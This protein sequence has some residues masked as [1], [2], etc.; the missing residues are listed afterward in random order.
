[1]FPFFELVL[2]VPSGA[3]SA[4]SALPQPKLSNVIRLK[5]AG[6]VTRWRFPGR[7]SSYY[8]RKFLRG[9]KL[10]IHEQLEKMRN[11]SELIS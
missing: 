2:F 9:L 3:R 10:I 5:F 1:M 11:V 7:N 4:S 8:G 6:E